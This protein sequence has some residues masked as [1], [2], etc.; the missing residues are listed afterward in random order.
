MKTNY[1]KLITLLGK[2]RFKQGQFLA[3]YTTYQI[4]GP[5]DLFYEAKTEEELCQVVNL[6]QKL[7][8]KYFILGSG[9]NL[10]ISDLGF[11]G[12]VIHCQLDK[13]NFLPA[14]NNQSKVYVEAG[15]KLGNLLNLLLERSLGGLEFLAGIPGT[16]GGAVRGNA[17]AWQ[18]STGDFVSRVKILS[19]NQISWVDQKGCSFDYRESRF[20]HNSEI[21]LGAEFILSVV[22][23]S[24]IKKTI[25]ENGEK[26]NNQPKQPSAGCIFVNPKPFSAGELIDKAGLK[27]KSIGQAQIS[28]LHA[29]FIVN[30]GGAK[31]SDVQSLI[32]E[33]KKTVKEQ[34]K[35]DLVEEIVKI[36]EF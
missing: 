27:G 5:A 24:I 10:L 32:L 34:F 29:N 11:K 22:D 26:R 4:G 16:L 17:G 21:I 31:A 18:Q 14:E 15:V 6:A 25:V 28:P 30:L 33:A 8:I 20:K 13:I 3:E 7:K 36:G 19:N 1:Q 35:I 23:R 9:S 12:L 2:D